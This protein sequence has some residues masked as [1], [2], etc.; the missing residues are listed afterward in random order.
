[1]EEQKYGISKLVGSYVNS[2]DHVRVYGELHLKM[3]E[4]LFF[5]REMEGLLWR[6]SVSDLK[7]KNE[8]VLKKEMVGNRRSDLGVHGIVSIR[9]IVILPNRL[10]VL[11]LVF[12]LPFICIASRRRPACNPADPGLL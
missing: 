5:V 8:R 9:Y 7:M 3:I 12:C 10:V 11:Y 6:L 2:L 4:L 1:M